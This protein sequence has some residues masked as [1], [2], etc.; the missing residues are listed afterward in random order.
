M[1]VVS[2]VDIWVVADSWSSDWV[3]SS[4][5]MMVP[6]PW[7]ISW[8]MISW[9]GAWVSG[10]G[11]RGNVGVCIGRNVMVVVFR[12]V[13]IRCWAVLSI[14]FWEMDVAVDWVVVMLLVLWQADI[15][16]AIAIMAKRVCGCACS[17]ALQGV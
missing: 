14:S 3:S 11:I 1:V 9:D 5:M 6:P 16:R 17:M 8:V 2:W 15:R 12:W 13:D 4:W 10:D 7:F